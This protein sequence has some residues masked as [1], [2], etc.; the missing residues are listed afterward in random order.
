LSKDELCK[1]DQ[2]IWV[3]FEPK[4]EISFGPK[5][6]AYKYT[7]ILLSFLASNFDFVNMTINCAKNDDFALLGVK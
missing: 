1:L 7:A 3:R 2:A 5:F 6:G 4:F